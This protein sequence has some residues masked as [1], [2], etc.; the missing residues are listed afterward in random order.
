M[1]STP[2]AVCRAVRPGQADRLL[3]PAASGCGTTISRGRSPH[4]ASGIAMTAASSTC[5]GA[6]AASR[7]CAGAAV[8]GCRGKAVLMDTAAG[9]QAVQSGVRHAAPAARAPWGVPSLHSP[10]GCCSAT[11]RRCKGRHRVRACGARQ[12]LCSATQ[13]LRR[14]CDGTHSSCTRPQQGAA[15]R[16]QLRAPLDDVLAAVTDAHASQLIN[17]CHIACRVQ[18]AAAVPCDDQGTDVAASQA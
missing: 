9:Q 4:T 1:V 17:A 8:P 13:L 7:A 6:S 16:P 3:S 15:L 10:V 2:S 11:R 14:T 5:G 12:A 18:K